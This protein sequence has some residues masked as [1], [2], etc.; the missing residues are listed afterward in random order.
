MTF[1]AC[2]DNIQDE[3]II[4][5]TDFNSNISQTSSFCGCNSTLKCKKPCEKKAHDCSEVKKRISNMSFCPP[6]EP[7]QLSMMKKMLQE[8]IDACSNVQ[9][10]TN[11][12][13]SNVSKQHSL[14][15]PKRHIIR[16]I[17]ENTNDLECPSNPCC[18]S[19]ERK[20]RME[21]VTN[22]LV[23]REGI[24]QKKIQQ[25]REERLKR[26]QKN[27]C[28]G[29]DE[30]KKDKKCA[31]DDSNDKCKA[32]CKK[33]KKM[34]YEIEL[35]N[36]L[37]DKLNRDLQIKISK[38]YP[39]TIVQELNI[40][41]EREIM[42]LKEMIEFTIFEQCQN[43]DLGWGTIP[44]S[45]LTS[46]S[47]SIPESSCG[48]PKSPCVS[49]V[50]TFSMLE[51]LNLSQEK[52][53]HELQS[54]FQNNKQKHMAMILNEIKELEYKLCELKSSQLQISNSI[55]SLYFKKSNDKK[56]SK[57]TKLVAKTKKIEQIKSIIDKAKE[58]ID[59]I[60]MGIHLIRN[61]T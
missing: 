3:K 41:L 35:Q 52:E 54:E 49:S 26:L 6:K 32:Y 5:K 16:K 13:E 56:I 17:N 53:K 19:D 28:D 34:K 48:I 24:R 12:K 7:S 9:L 2:D 50:S 33:Y 45:P 46:K 4:Q 20:E 8:R 59:K 37:V 55:R 36:Y 42:K 51:E 18:I 47:I 40:D 43:K 61:E 58:D 27:Q 11:K 15:K 21:T 25:Q 60:H 23:Q 1:S 38:N 10:K 39:E 31:E 29:M 44:I 22:K 30:C 14:S 57:K